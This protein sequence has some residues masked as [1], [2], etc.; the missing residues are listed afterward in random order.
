MGKRGPQ[1]ITT[2]SLTH[3]HTPPIIIML[4]LSM[5]LN[6]GRDANL[7]IAICNHYIWLKIY[8]PQLRLQTAI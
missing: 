4:S 6:C 1:Y 2:L 8:K 7:D 3:T 5:V